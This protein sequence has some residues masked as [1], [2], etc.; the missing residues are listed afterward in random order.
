MLLQI[1]KSH[2]IRIEMKSFT[3]IIYILFINIIHLIHNLELNKNAHF[4]QFAGN[5]SNNNNLIHRVQGQ[6]M[7]QSAFCSVLNSC[8]EQYID[9]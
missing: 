7:I 5:F 2:N 9:C 4:Y 6:E 3:N 1:V 8:R